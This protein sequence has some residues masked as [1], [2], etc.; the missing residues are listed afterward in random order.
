MVHRQRQNFH[1][2]AKPGIGIVKIKYNRR[3]PGNSCVHLTHENTTSL[4][5]LSLML[6]LRKT[7]AD[8]IIGECTFSSLK[9]PLSLLGEA[10]F[11]KE[12]PFPGGAAQNGLG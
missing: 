6:Y 9:T 4:V 1:G 12:L 2:E 7:L 10:P 8:E 3:S 5:S 11:S